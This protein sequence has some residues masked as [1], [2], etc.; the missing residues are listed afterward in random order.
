MLAALSISVIDWNESL[1]DFTIRLIVSSLCGFAIGFERKTRSKE[2]GIRTHAIVAL[3]ATLMMLVSKYGFAES[4]TKDSARIA[5]QIV[6]G[7]GFLGAG[8]IFYRR[9]MLHGLTTAAGIWAT[10]G[11]GMAIGAGMVATGT[12]STIILLVLQIFLHR[13]IKLFRGRVVTILRM[14]VKI[15]N[16]LTVD[17]IQYMFSAKKFLK[18]KTSNSNGDIMAEIEL[19][20]DKV[21]TAKE[22]YEI[23][24]TTPFIIHL[25]KTDEI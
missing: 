13:P 4:E 1:F 16:D 21:F 5:A 25:E 14:S 10:A 6:S 8:I 7:I 15:E 11:I 17:T 12:I 24:S 19:S 20:T 3:A 2:A 18:F 23:A 9:D 22:I